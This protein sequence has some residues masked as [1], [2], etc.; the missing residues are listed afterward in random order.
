MSRSQLAINCPSPL[1]IRLRAEAMSRKVT[2]TSLLLQWIEAGL[3]GQ[4]ATSSP[5]AS[6]ALEARLEAVERRLDAMG[7]LEAPSPPVALAAAVPLPDC[8][9]TAAEADGVMTL[10]E[11]AKLLGLGGGGSAIT[12]WIGKEARK[13]DGTPPI[14]AVYRGG[15]Q[16]LGKG[17][18]PNGLKAGWLFRAI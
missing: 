2:I 17:L 6:T 8:R 18:L 3:A 10:P 14:G 13:N 15:F 1:L 9:L 7:A 12:N 11:V 16:L 5:P 4:L